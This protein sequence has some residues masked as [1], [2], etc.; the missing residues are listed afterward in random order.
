MYYLLLPFLLFF[1]LASLYAELP[2]VL[3]YE[4]P[5]E[6]IVTNRILATVNGV[7]ISVIDVMKKMDM[8]LQRY[9][10]ERFSFKFMRFQHY[11]KNWRDTLIQMIDQELMLADAQ[12]LDVKVSD[13]EVREEML[14]RFGANMMMTLDMMGISSEE[15]RMQ[16]HK[17]IVV[18][19]IMWYRVHSK[20]FNMVGPQDIKEAYRL[21]CKHNPPIEKWNYQVLSIR[22]VSESIGALLAKRAFD[23]LEKRDIAFSLL[24]EALKTEQENSQVALSAELEGD[25]KSLS[26]S[27]KEVL[28]QLEPGT[29]SAPIA[30]VSRHDHSTVYRIFYLKEHQ[31]QT[32]PSFEK[33][34]EEL[35]EH[36]LQQASFK[37]STH[38]IAKLRQRYGFEEA[39]ML[40]IPEDFQPFAIR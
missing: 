39:K 20:V 32:P 6:I 38:Y 37:E 25:E 33:M 16:I 5:Q 36:L 22:S 17:E 7:S 10:P 2:G 11:S 30:Q 31:V 28:K 13:A 14:R 18:Q 26:I 24:P 1:S 34:A 29:F 3:A 35:K 40:H 15:A 9:Y 8:V 27:H 21:F 4:E 12:H 19:K 23:L